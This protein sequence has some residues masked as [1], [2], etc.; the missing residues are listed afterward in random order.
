MGDWKL[1]PFLFMITTK[2][3]IL[4]ESKVPSTWVFEYYLD[5]PERLT[6]QN[7]KIQ[8]IFNPTERT[9][10]M[11]V[12][13]DAKN[14]QYKYKDFSTGNY[15]SKVDIVME[16]FNLNYSKSLFKIIEDYNK[17]IL[18]KGNYSKS[19]IK[20]HSKYSSCKNIEFDITQI[21]YLEKTDVLGEVL[22]HKFMKQM[23]I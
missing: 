13:L 5:L 17:F 8:S 11:W 19:E 3:L 22:I 21:K 7:V 2:N 14:S 9:P 15:G 10:S 20:Q 4:D 16:I 18:D 12:F 23:T 1:S 6:G